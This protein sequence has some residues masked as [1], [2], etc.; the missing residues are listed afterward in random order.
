MINS[1]Y[2]YSLLFVLVS[3]FFVLLP[4]LRKNKS[5]ES[6]PNANA[7]RIAD[8][9]SRIIELEQEIATGKLTNEAFETAVVEQKRRL[10]NDLSPE[11]KSTLKVNRMVIALT[12]SLFVITFCGVFYAMTGNFGLLVQW[13]E[14]RD[15]LPELGKRAVLQQGDPLSNN[16]LQQ[17]ALGLRTKLAEQGDDEMA[18]LLLGRVMMSQNDFESANHAFDKVIAMNSSNTNALLS[19]AQLLTL[20]GDEASINQAAQLISLSCK[21]NLEI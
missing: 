21:L 8:F 12:A 2:T 13:Q 11:S 16:D 19:K 10:M 14:A 6:N 20:K 3:L 4:F 9:E 1:F 5:I 18:W 15:N 7:L 17:F